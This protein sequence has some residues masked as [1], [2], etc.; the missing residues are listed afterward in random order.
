[1]KMQSIGKIYATPVE[2]GAGLRLNGFF[3]KKVCGLLRKS[4]TFFNG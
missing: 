3:L 4:S 2:K 1:M